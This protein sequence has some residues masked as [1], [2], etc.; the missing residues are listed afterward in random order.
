[1]SG[2]R[3]WSASD[4]LR[5]ADERTRPAADLLSRVALDRP[6]RVA[7]LG[8]GPG[9]S[10][11]LLARRFSEA[12]IVGV[13]SSPDMLAA[14]A[15]RLPS[16]RFE[17]ADAAAWTPD[18]PLDLLFANALLQ[19]L[20]HHETLF[21]RLMGHLAPGGVLAA[22]LPDNMA[23]PSH[24][25]MA[26]VARDPRWAGRLV[27]AEAARTPILSAESYYDLLAP[28]SRSID[29]WRTNYLH[30]L[31]GAEAIAGW[32]RSTGLRPYL[33]P[34]T[35]EE[36]EAFVALYTERMRAAYPA[37]VDGRVLLPFPRLFIVAVR[38]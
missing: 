25:A 35:G 21:P 19:W 10:T 3:D 36:G 2:R 9:N 34:L 33:G 8:C 30:P 12:D 1:M 20:P 7:D 11:E 27:N 13:D 24:L 31:D 14:A 4:Y 32:F 16:A 22:Q 37:R 17:Q 38:S 23:E 18:R 29:I 28:R 6:S 26:E 15:K 5:F